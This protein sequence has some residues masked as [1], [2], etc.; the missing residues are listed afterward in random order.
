MSKVMLVVPTFKYRDKYP[1]FLS[2]SDFP[3]GFGYLAS[4]LKAAGHEV[5]GVNPNNITGYPSARIMLQNVLSQK[6]S[7]YKPDIIATGGLCTDY[8][9]FNDLVR[10]S[11]ALCPETPIVLG[12]QIVTN[13]PE[14]VYNLLKPD[15]VVVGEGERAIVDIADCKFP[16][17]PSP[18]WH[19][20]YI[21]DLDSLPFPDFEPFGVM[22][23]LDNYSMATRLLY[24][25]S[26]TK[27]RPFVLVASRS[28]PFT[29][30][31]CVDSHRTIP[32]RARS[33]ASIMQEIKAS[34]SKYHYNILII[35]DELFAVNKDRLNAFSE[36]ILEGKEQYGW[37]FDWCFQTHASAK[38]DIDSLK[39][40]KRAG[41]YLFSYGLESASQRVLESMNKKTD[42][43]QVIEAL[44]LAHQAN[45]GFSGNLIFGDVAENQNTWA[46]SLSFWLEY[47]RKDF[48][49]LTN[50]MPYPGSKIFNQMREY[51]AFKD[52]RLYYENIDKGAINMTTMPPDLFENLCK[53]IVGLETSWMFV[54]LAT[55]VKTE[56]EEAVDY[57]GHHIYTITCKCPHCGEMIEYRQPMN[58]ETSSHFSLGTGCTNCNRKI[59]IET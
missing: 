25:Y 26:R 36:A 44:E 57:E 8:A 54:D 2:M 40:A 59:K 33:I 30:S 50:L 11:R 43:N 3:T 53:L 56:R 29:C 5:I 21:K 24:R 47:G 55:N 51:G 14:D 23:M 34:Y 16:P 48:I 32:Y 1:S 38:L 4:S 19:S 27:P 52:K 18:I 9:F 17:T 13:D 20:E 10:F 46:E 42:I 41:C 49:F 39:L 22:D 6:I 45:I 35:D 37:D 7:Q 58:D 31:F 15:W 12:G 28:C